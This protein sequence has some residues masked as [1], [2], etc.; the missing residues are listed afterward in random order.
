MKHIPEAKKKCNQLK[1]QKV[2]VQLSTRCNEWLESQKNNAMW[3]T[4]SS[5]VFQLCD[6]VPEQ[7][8]KSEVDFLKDR[9]ILNSNQKLKSFSQLSTKANVRWK[10][11]NTTRRYHVPELNAKS[12][13]VKL[14]Y[15]FNLT[16]F[17]NSVIQY[18]HY[19]KKAFFLKMVNFIGTTIKLRKIIE[20]R[21]RIYEI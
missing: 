1:N 9:K 12:I 16:V 3:Q 6:R 11:E 18:T 15:R 8:A 14:F 4:F 13:N 21:I 19:I 5:T 10:V 20:I 17:Y 2:S 7:N